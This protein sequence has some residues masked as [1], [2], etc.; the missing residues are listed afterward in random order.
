MH[1]NL[2]SAGH[3]RLRSLIL[4][5]QPVD[6]LPTVNS[7]KAGQA[8]P[9]KFSLGGNRGP[10]IF[11]AGCAKAQQVACS[12]GAPTDEIEQTTTAS[13]SGLKHNAPA[14]QYGY[15]WKTD[16]EWAGSCRLLTIKL[17]EGS[18]QSALFQFR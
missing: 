2:S 6:D 3:T 7:V 4:T 18:E 13:A 9:F 11:A 14:G 8:V 17:I 15:T 16:K 1:M 10:N 5:F 12:S